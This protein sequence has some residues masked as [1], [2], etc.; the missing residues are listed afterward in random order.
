MVSS[1]GEDGKGTL[2]VGGA[3]LPFSPQGSG[4][5]LLPRATLLPR[6]MVYTLLQ[7]LSFSKLLAIKCPPKGREVERVK[8]KTRK[9]ALALIALCWMGVD[10]VFGR[11]VG[12][13]KPCQKKAGHR[14]VSRAEGKY[15]FS[16]QLPCPYSILMP[17]QRHQ[18]PLL[19][20]P[21]RP[22]M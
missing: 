3:P 2:L 10:R 1:G 13:T 8:P 18:R 17:T 20:K 14:L 6:T 5:L 9:D 16:S 15:L 19:S 11:R 4:F 22:D 12:V 7:K 21:P